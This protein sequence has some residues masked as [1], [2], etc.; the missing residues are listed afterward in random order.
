MVLMNDAGTG[1]SPANA[2][3]VAS[4]FTANMVTGIRHA[5]TQIVKKSKA[6]ARRRGAEAKL[7]P[8]FELILV[9]MRTERARKAVKARRPH[10]TV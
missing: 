6:G 3:T 1:V 10:P 2:V 8:R 4:R 9:R 5:R 7:L